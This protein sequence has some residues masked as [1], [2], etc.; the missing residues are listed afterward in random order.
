M[1]ELPSFNDDTFSLQLYDAKLAQ[2]LTPEELAVYRSLT[3]DGRIVV[4]HRLR[5]GDSFE[6]AKR[7]L[8][9]LADETTLFESNRP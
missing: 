2:T 7:L 9:M 3:V 5:N 4:A 1:H 8:F 6:R